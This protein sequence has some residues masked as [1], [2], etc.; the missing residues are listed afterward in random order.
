[1]DPIQYPDP[2]SGEPVSKTPIPSPSD[3]TASLGKKCLAECLG[4]FL[5][6]LFGCGAVH[7]AVLTGA[8]SGLWQVAIV[9]GIAI[10]VAIYTVG[11]VSG[12][13]I[14][15]AITVAFAVWGRFPWRSVVPYTLSQ[16]AG[17]F[18]AAAILFVLFN[19]FLAARE[20]ERQV[21]R[22]QPGSEVT[23]MCYGEY[24]P[25][26]GPLSNAPGP[27]SLAAHERLNAL[28]SQPAAFLAELL[29]TLILAMVVFAGDRRPQSRSP[30]QSSG[31]SVH[32]TDRIGPDLGHRSLDPGVLQ[33]GERFWS[34]AFRLF[35]RMGANRSARPSGS[36]V[37]HRVHPRTDP[38]SDRGSRALPLSACSFQPLSRHPRVV[39]PCKRHRSS[40]LADSWAPEK[41]PSWR[42]P[43]SNWFVRASAWA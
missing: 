29:G 17:A 42:E 43:P 8:Q 27:Y 5:L 19:P 10:M 1:M 34:P 30:A 6:I 22:G 40:L 26:P 20:Q 11:A 31:R 35:R 13:H 38:R 41:R 18:V 12:A 21:V 33:P 9:W 25:S 32:R 16:T 39:S 15:P 24:F 36:R 14:N 2:H 4:T 23:A 37:L 3:E 7:A 28:V